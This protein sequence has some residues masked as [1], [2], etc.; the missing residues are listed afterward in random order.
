[1]RIQKFLKNTILA[2]AALAGMIACG[3]QSTTSSVGGIEYTREEA[4]YD[5]VEN[6]NRYMAD[7]ELSI[8]KMDSKQLH[9]FGAQ[10]M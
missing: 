9:L 10:K 7:S 8:E 2:G 3:G 5:F 4:A 1:M 6:V